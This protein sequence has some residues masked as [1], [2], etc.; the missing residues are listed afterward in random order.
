MQRCYILS[1][2]QLIAQITNL[3]RKCLPPF[4]I[5]TDVANDIGMMIMNLDFKLRQLPFKL[6][7]SLRPVLLVPR[8]MVRLVG[9]LSTLLT[10]MRGALSKKAPALTASQLMNLE[11]ETADDEDELMGEVKAGDSNTPTLSEKDD[12]MTFLGS[13]LGGALQ[14]TADAAAEAEAMPEE[15]PP[16]AVIQI[17]DEDGIVIEAEDETP[18]DELEEKTDGYA[19]PAPMPQRMERDQRQDASV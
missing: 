16:G 12:A 1:C 13:E 14:E 4:P 7:K 11:G 2:T 6:G 17:E 9:S 18:Y 19:Q 8:N 10:M 3:V 5:V 15:A